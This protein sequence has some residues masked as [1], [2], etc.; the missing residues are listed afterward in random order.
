[1]MEYW[2]NGM[3]GKKTNAETHYSIIPSFQDSN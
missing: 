1:M 2:N 3:L